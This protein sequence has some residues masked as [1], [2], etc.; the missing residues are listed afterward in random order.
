MLQGIVV[1]HFFK[2]AK[3]QEEQIATWDLTFKM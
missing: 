2:L 3:Y 1:L